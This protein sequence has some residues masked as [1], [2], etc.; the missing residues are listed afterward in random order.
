[1]NITEEKRYVYDMMRS[2][3]EERR[4]LT[5][6]YYSL[7]K[8]LDSLEEMEIKGLDELS[9][10][11]QIDLYNERQQ[12]LSLNNVK[13]ELNHISHKIETQ[14]NSDEKDLPSPKNDSLHSFAIAERKFYDNQRKPKPVAQRKPRK[15]SE[16]GRNK[17]EKITYI[18]NLIMNEMKQRSDEA[19]T[20]KQMYEILLAY[21]QFRDYNVELNEF[22]SNIFYR[23]VKNNSD[24]IVKV[25]KGLFQYAPSKQVAN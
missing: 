23:I 4:T 24:T 12:E 7:K 13:R 1:M 14:K 17:S 11:G 2:I 20:A 9:L 5:D 18:H 19:F 22:R 10:K 15:S 25:D 3:M 21:Q 16:K 8:R 6:I